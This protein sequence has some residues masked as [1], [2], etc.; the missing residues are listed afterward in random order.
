MRLNGASFNSV[1]IHGTARLRV[2]GESDAPAVVASELDAVRIQH[3]EAGAP[4]VLAGGFLG[5]CQRYF[6]EALPAEFAIT[7]GPMVARSGTGAA[8]AALEGS[9]YYTRTQLIFGSALL[10][11]DARGYVGVVF[12]DGDAIATPGEAELDGTRVRLGHGEDAPAALVG[13]LSASALRRGFTADPQDL[14]LAGEMEAS[15]VHDGVRYIG[16]AGDLVVTLHA[17]DGGMLRQNLIGSL[18]Y[19]RSASG[20]GRVMRRPFFD[21]AP[22]EFSMS[23][24]FLVYRR[25][26]NVP[27][28]ALPLVLSAE[29]P[30]EIHVR[31]DGQAVAVLAT[32][33]AGY[34]YRRTATGDLV[35]AMDVTMDGSRIRNMSVEAPQFSLASSLTAARVRHGDGS[36][37]L[38]AIATADGVVNLDREDTDIEQFYRPAMVRAFA[39]P[40]HVREWR[41]A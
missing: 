13:E 30:A 38:P 25:A 10:E 40:A 29:F 22:I 36:L 26:T 27:G 7:L 5:S 15:H 35:H 18:D 21:L 41:R 4:V 1:P 14:A 39:R 6:G 20:S 31:G 37:I 33:C 8:V 34:V 3:G 11:M 19:T 9:L 23:G 32:A 2:S 16:G 24:E 12:I 28:V 17:E